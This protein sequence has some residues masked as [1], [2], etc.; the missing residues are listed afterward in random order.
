[1]PIVFIFIG[2]CAKVVVD[3]ARSRNIKIHKM[4][5]I[6]I[7]LVFLLEPL[8]KTT[9][10]LAN[11][12]QSDSRQAAAGWI[13]ENLQKD[14]VTYGFASACWGN[15][16]PPDFSFQRVNYF[17]PPDL[18]KPFDYFVLDSW[19]FDHFGPGTDMQ[20]MP[21]YSEM[22]FSNPTEYYPIDH[23]AK[24]VKYLQRYVLVKEFSKK[25]YYG[26][27]IWIYQKK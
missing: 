16:F 18:D 24:M 7:G 22:I 5:W 1:L 11:D 12:F 15:P 4:S 3:F 8:Y 13:K 10:S 20:L 14:N 17:S 6:V 25:D 23:R 27:T 26:P 21:V 19:L 2:Y 9:A